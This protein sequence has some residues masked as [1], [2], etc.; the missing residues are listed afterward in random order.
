MSAVYYVYK[1]CVYFFILIHIDNYE[2]IHL[3]LLMLRETLSAAGVIT[4]VTRRGLCVNVSANSSS[5]GAQTLTF[6][7][8]IIYKSV[9][10]T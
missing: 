9:W 4:N 10:A 6:C 7:V 1:P 8:P 3:M 2:Y 5:L